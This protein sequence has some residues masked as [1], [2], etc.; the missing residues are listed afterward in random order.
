[1]NPPSSQDVRRWKVCFEA[2]GAGYR[3]GQAVSVA[4]VGLPAHSDCRKHGR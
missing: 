2:Q 4:R 3:F 1:M